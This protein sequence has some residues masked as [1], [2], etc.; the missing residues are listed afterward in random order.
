MNLAN[1]VFQSPYMTRGSILIIDDE[2]RL[3]NVLSR[4]IELEGYQVFQAENAT[5]A[6]HLLDQ[7]KDILVV[8]ADVRLPDDNGLI[9]LERVKDKYPQSEVILLT[10]YGSIHDGVKAMKLGAFDYITKGDGDEQIL[11]VIDK[12]F[13]KAKMRKRI[14]E[15]EDKLGARYSFDRIIG[16]SV[17]IRESLSL[18]QRVAPTDST[19]I[20]E[21]ETGTGK[22]L[23]AQSIHNASPR[24]GKPFVPVNCSAIPKE[25]LESEMFGH[26]KGAFT[27]ALFDKKGLFEEANEGTLF[28]DEIGEMNMDLQSKLLRVLEEQEFTRIGETRPMKVN[29]RIIAATNRDLSEDIRNGRFR[30]DLY[31]RLSVFRIKIPPLR[32]RRE[33]I[34]SLAAYF[35]DL[36]SAGIKKKILGMAPEFI[37]KLETYNWPGNTRELKNIIERAVILTDK[38]ILTADLFPVDMVTREMPTVPSTDGYSL[39]DTE[40]R[41]I[42]KVLA[43]TQ[44]NKSKAA[45]KLG[46]GVP[47][48]YRKM[49]EYD[50]R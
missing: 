23:F 1:F 42:L 47:T 25:L 43:I 7:E 12:A 30:N 5:K 33:D 26:R 3:R 27:G 13:E 22:E 50:I 49:K 36:F 15:L 40:K 35:V 20:L 32:E 38:E 48:L 6:Y 4:I 11:V 9:V 37:S 29:V 44:G 16:N 21:G 18:A 8:V 10:A 41:Q 34:E 2:D 14:L 17:V 45:K 46:I 24:K 19:V 28:L 39:R 31:F